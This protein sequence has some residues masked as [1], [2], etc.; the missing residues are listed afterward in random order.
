M[1]L[2]DDGVTTTEFTNRGTV[3]VPGLFVLKGGSIF[4]GTISV[5]PGGELRQDSTATTHIN[6]GAGAPGFINSDGGLIRAAQGQLD[7]FNMNGGALNNATLQS[8]AGATLSLQLGG[9]KTFF[10]TGGVTFTGGGVIAPIAS[11]GWEPAT[12]CSISPGRAVSVRWLAT[13]R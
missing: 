7:V 4:E 1:T 2:G 8:D 12:C 13:S 3:F 5:L 10:V 9:S 11:L 6:N